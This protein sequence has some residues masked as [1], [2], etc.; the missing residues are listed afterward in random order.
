MATSN[1]SYTTSGNTL[2]ISDGRNQ[3]P[4]AYCVSGSTLT[5]T[6]TFTQTGTATGTIVLQKL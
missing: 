2:S 4:Y 1:G 5:M 3:I 6:P